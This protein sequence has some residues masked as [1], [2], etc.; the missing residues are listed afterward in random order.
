TVELRSNEKS[1]TKNANGENLP[2][3]Q[4]H[5]YADGDGQFPVQLNDWEREVI[6]TEIARPS[7]VAWYRNPQRATPNS[8]R[9][10][11]ETEAGKW[12]SLQIDFLVVSRLDDRTFAA[13]IV[14]PHG[15]HLADAKAK[16][17][18]LADFTESQ[19]DRFLR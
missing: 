4:G 5:I 14:D 17:R 16:L 18:A 15:D 6:E 7:F 12:S 1:A 9:I 19:A 11:Y 13:S 8:L 2:T 3:F 10:A